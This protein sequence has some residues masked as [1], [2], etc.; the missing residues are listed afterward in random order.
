MKTKTESCR[1]NPANITR[2]TLEYYKQTKN[3]TSDVVLECG[4]GLACGTRGGRGLW[5]TATLSSFVTRPRPTQNQS[6]SRLDSR[7]CRE[8][9][10]NVKGL[11]EYLT[12]IWSPEEKRGRKGEEPNWKKGEEKKM[13]L[14][15]TSEI[16]GLRSKLKVGRIKLR[17]KTWAK[18]LAVVN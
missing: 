16:Y 1:K 10:L 12:L 8:R 4:R 5:W 13:L 14:K 18:K 7:H 9:R 17:K 11:N 3:K 15:K 2:N 6:E